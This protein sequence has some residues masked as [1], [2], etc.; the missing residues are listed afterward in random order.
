MVRYQVVYA[1]RHRITLDVAKGITVSG[2]T[3]QGRL[4]QS[5]HA[6]HGMT[7]PPA[8]SRLRPRMLDLPQLAALRRLNRQP[9]RSDPSL[10]GNTELMI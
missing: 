4:H 7:I 10:Q 3:R 5:E 8:S 2:W 1:K 6:A 9:Q